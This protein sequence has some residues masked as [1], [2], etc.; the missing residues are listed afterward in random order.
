MVAVFD[1]H[2]HRLVETLAA[3]GS[4]R[5]LDMRGHHR[6]A[7]IAGQLDVSTCVAR[8]DGAAFVA[9]GAPQAT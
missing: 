5:E 6:D 7:A 3:C 8:F 2:R 4:G 1:H 9:I